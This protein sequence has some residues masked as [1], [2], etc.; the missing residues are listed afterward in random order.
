M[1]LVHG[2]KFAAVRNPDTAE[3]A[4]A[5]CELVERRG[6]ETVAVIRIAT[7]QRVPCDTLML[8]VLAH[9]DHRAEGECVARSRNCER[10]DQAK[11]G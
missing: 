6:L 4:F 3:I 2:Q 11:A 8:G 7:G 1:H 5:A 9:P 10:C